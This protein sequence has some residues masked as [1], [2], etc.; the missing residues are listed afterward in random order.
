MKRIIIFDEFTSSQLNG[1]G[2]F[3]KELYSRC[4]CLD[5][6]QPIFVSF[7]N[8]ISGLIITNETNGLRYSFPIIH[9]GQFLE[10]GIQIGSVLRLYI[11]DTPDNIFI[12][13]YSPCLSFLRALKKLYPKSKFVFIIHNQGWNTPLLGNTT[14]L[15]QIYTK[16]LNHPSLDIN[17]IKYIRRYCTNEKKVYNMV[18]ATICLSQST[19]D[20]LS[21]IYK[22]NRTNIYLI[23][24]GVTHNP[25]SNI[26]STTEA[27][28]LIGVR[29]NETTILFVGRI[30][31]A[32]GIIDLLQAFE[33][34]AKGYPHLRLLI[35]GTGSEVL[36]YLKSVE[37]ATRSKISFLGHAPRESLDTIYAAADI[38]IIPSYSEQCSFVAL[39]MMI[40][41]KFI[42]SSDAIGLKDMFISGENALV[43]SRDDTC[44]T[45]DITIRKA[46][47]MPSDKR[48]KLMHACK[49]SALHLFSLEEQYS[50]LLTLLSTL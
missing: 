43:Y 9:N 17:T 31:Q 40:R 25:D 26:L 33:E 21:N 42:I 23:P 16:R 38:C 39:E 48:R 37:I 28:N 19:K 35:V 14:I 20:I 6:V 18:D 49:Q 10:A 44:R 32:K 27:K 22:L 41:G 3:T 47:N 7:N 46:L 30:T 15:N 1:V 50:K 45:L 13:N 4:A 24:N 5:N 8:P 11:T 2:V 34:V 29:D 36:E 12:L